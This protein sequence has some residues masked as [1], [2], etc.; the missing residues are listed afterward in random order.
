MPEA[1]QELINKLKDIREKK[2]VTATVSP[3]STSQ[4]PIP[5]NAPVPIAPTSVNK[6]SLP[7]NNNAP[8]AQVNMSSVVRPIFTPSPPIVT[9]TTPIASASV[10]STTNTSAIT[11]IL[12]PPPTMHSPSV[13]LSQPPTNLHIDTP[14]KA[15]EQF[16][17]LLKS[18]NITP[19]WHWEDAMREIITDPRYRVFK[20]TA[21]RK[22]AFQLY[23]DMETKRQREEKE[24]K[25]KKEQDDFFNMLANIPQIK[26]YYSFRTILPL[27]AQQPAYQQLQHRSERHIQHL[28]QDYIYDLRK[29]EKER[30]RQQRKKDIEHVKQYLLTTYQNNEEYENGTKLTWKD[31][32]QKHQKEELFKDIDI[33]DILDGFQEFHRIVWEK[34]L[35]DFEKKIKWQQHQ[36]RLARD[37]F[38]QLLNELEKQEKLN[39]H[40]QWKQIYPLIYEDQR[41]IQL[42][43]VPGSTPID[44]FWDKLDELDYILYQQRKRVQDYIKHHDFQIS[45]DTT[46]DQY[47]EFIHKSSTLLD[48]VDNINIPLIY[49]ELHK[50]E[51]RKQQELERKQMKKVQRKIKSLKY[52]IRKLDSPPVQLNDT[53]ETVRIRLKDEDALLDLKENEEAQKEAFTQ[54]I[55]KLEAKHNG[56]EAMDE[57]DEEDEDEEEGIIKED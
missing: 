43:G 50:K 12:P 19:D 8:L 17:S 20:T 49:T 27:I 3:I 29:Q 54:V 7:I 31:I 10:T 52:A 9:P 33:M 44:L 45:V 2:T 18:K 51:I 39:A 4:S 14:E 37:R 48:Q 32:K 57:E 36:D 35:D 42:L 5:I 23:V 46:L 41:Y 15:M 13:L 55:K 53:W 28:Y 40:T 47:L 22:N 11:P 25:V 21:E 24:A 6:Q 34:P 38:K 16:H 56:K 30:K 1:Y 26:A